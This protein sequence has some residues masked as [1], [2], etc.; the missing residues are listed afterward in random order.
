MSHFIK[1]CLQCK[2]VITQCRCPS[3]NKEERWDIC[4]DCAAK[5]TAK[6]K[7]DLLKDFDQGRP[8]S[9]T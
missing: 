7:E 6:L 3:K 4:S 1:K 2:A 8:R 9:T 5:A